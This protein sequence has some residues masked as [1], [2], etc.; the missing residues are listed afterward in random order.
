VKTTLIDREG[1]KDHVK[2]SASFKSTIIT[3]KRAGAPFEMQKL[4]KLSM[5]DKT[6]KK[7]LLNLMTIQEK[8]V[9]LFED[10][11]VRFSVPEAKFVASS[12]WFDRFKA[13]ANFHAVRLQ[14]QI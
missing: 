8:P 12:G 4:L 11:K 5:E 13:R 14:V 7:A 6:Q 10:V 3:K 2:G 9:R 1:I